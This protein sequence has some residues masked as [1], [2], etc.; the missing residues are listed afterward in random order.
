MN[1]LIAEYFSDVWRATINKVLS[2]DTRRTGFEWKEDYTDRYV[3]F[4]QRATSMNESESE[5]SRKPT[6]RGRTMS[7]NARQ[8]MRVLADGQNT[9]KNHDSLY[10]DID[11]RRRLGTSFP[12]KNRTTIKSSR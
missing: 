5:S 11:K 6:G 7:E 9:S 1:G 10:I 3:Q 2:S 8:P 4:L 12:N